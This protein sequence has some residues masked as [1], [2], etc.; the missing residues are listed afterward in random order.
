MIHDLMVESVYAAGVLILLCLA[1]SFHQQVQE[2]WKMRRLTATKRAVSTD[3][4]TRPF[5]RTERLAAEREVDPIGTRARW[6]AEIESV[7]RQRWPGWQKVETL[8]GSLSYEKKAPEASLTGSCGAEWNPPRWRDV[9]E[10]SDSVYGGVPTEGTPQPQ[11]EFLREVRMTHA[12]SVVVQWIVV[13][14]NGRFLR[15]AQSPQVVVQRN[16]RKKS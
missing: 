11:R 15:V 6:E 16:R 10:T 3:P 4:L 14:E 2:E 13:D 5:S 8:D 1:H 12:H 7:R 9:L